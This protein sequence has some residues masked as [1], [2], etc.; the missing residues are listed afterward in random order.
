MR[1]VLLAGLFCVSVNAATY[2]VTIAGLGGTA[3]YET[4]FQKWA[5]EL[6]RELG[7]NG[8]D[9]HIE[10]IAGA[11][12]TRQHI[13][14]V[15]AHLTQEVQPQDAIALFLI[16]HGTFDGTDYKFNVPGPDIT[17]GQLSTLMN[18]VRAGRQLV[19][20]MT[21]C[22]GASLAKLAKKDRIVI[23]A[24]KSGTEKNA[25]V[26]ARYWVDALQDPAADTDK[27]GTISALE[28]FRYAQ[29]KTTAYFESEKLLA[30]EHSQFSD[31]GSVTAVRDPKPENG[32]GLLASAFPL[33]RPA[34]DTS[35][36]VNPKKQNLL[37]RKQDLEAKIDQLKYRKAA[38]PEEQY[39]QE[40]TGLLLQLARTQAEIDK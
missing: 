34:T 35:A 9:A 23:T 11:A 14:A 6:G 3:E 22:S 21:S 10:T 15:F 12:A 25:T 2:Y 19:V 28:A 17:A 24:T 38:L 40:L 36:A 18:N 33:L 8:T 13:D 7:Q 29:Q 16:G 20:N 32:Q 37:G 4:Q 26:F 39:K 5:A 31:T 1:L 27:N 30:T